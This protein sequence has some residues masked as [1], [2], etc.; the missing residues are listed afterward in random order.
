M[1]SR[2]RVPRR[3]RLQFRS[4]CR[5]IAWHTPGAKAEL[6]SV[7]KMCDSVPHWKPEGGL[8][9]GNAEAAPPGGFVRRSEKFASRIAISV[10]TSFWSIALS[11]DRRGSVKS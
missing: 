8:T 2:V 11:R 4:T 3:V 9:R 10:I 6:K 1:N 7:E 5:R